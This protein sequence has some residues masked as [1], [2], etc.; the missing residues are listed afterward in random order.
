MRSLRSHSSY[1]SNSNSGCSNRVRRRLLDKDTRKLWTIN[2]YLRCAK[3][4]LMKCKVNLIQLQDLDP[5]LDCIQIR[6]S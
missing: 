3:M 5:T 1:S 4:N 2:M 6:H